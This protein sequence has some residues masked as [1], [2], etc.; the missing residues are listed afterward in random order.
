MNLPNLLEEK[1]ISTYWEKGHADIADYVDK[2]SSAAGS[3]YKVQDLNAKGDLLNLLNLH[4]EVSFR[5]ASN[6]KLS[7]EYTF[8]GFYDGM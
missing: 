3:K 6:F 4:G 2:S 1:I 7:S 8:D 5:F